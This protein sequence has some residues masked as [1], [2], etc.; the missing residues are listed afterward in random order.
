MS[1]PFAVP[2]G[3]GACPLDALEEGVLELV[4]SKLPPRDV[5]SLACASAGLRGAVSRASLRVRVD[6]EPLSRRDGSSKT[7]AEAMLAAL[8]A[9]APRCATLDLTGARVSDAAVAACVSRLPHLRAVVLD[10]CHGISASTVDALA[11]DDPETRPRAVALVSLQRCFGLLDGHGLDLLARALGRAGAKTTRAGASSATTTTHLSLSHRTFHRTAFRVDKKAPAPAAPPR[12]STSVPGASLSTL[13]LTNCAFH[14]SASAFVAALAEGAPAL[15]ALG[16]GGS[17]FDDDDDDDVG[18]PDAR[19]D[20]DAAEFISAPGTTTIPP[21]SNGA[22][23]ARRAAALARAFASSPRLRVLEATFGCPGDPFA[24]CAEWLA[25]AVD[26]VRNGGRRADDEN[27]NA[28]AADRTTEEPPRRTGTPPRPPP[29]PSLWDASD[30][31]CVKAL[32]EARA[33]NAPDGFAPGLS[34]VLRAAANCAPP[35]AFKATPLHHAVVASPGEDDDDAFDEK[36]DTEE[37]SARDARESSDDLRSR[38]ARALRDRAR[39]MGAGRVTTSAATSPPSGRAAA[40]RRLPFGYGGDARRRRVDARARP[41]PGGAFNVVRALL[42]FGADANARDRSGATPLFLAAEGGHREAAIDLLDAGA[43]L[44]AKNALGESAPYIAALKGR[45]RTLD[46]LLER[47]RAVGA[48]WQDPEW[49]GDGWTPLHAAACA[50]REDVAAV[51]IERAREEEEEEEEEEEKEGGSS[52]STARR[53]K[54]KEKPPPLLVRAKNRYG[55]TALHVAALLGSAGMVR[56]LLDAGAS[57]RAR[58]GNGMR[59]ADVAAREGHAEVWELLLEEAGGEE[60]DETTSSSPEDE[61][62][63]DAKK[64]GGAEAGG[65][66]K[67]GGRRRRRRRRGDRRA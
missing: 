42:A 40:P 33:A 48:P 17:R 47:C 5:A 61:E 66:R 13:S 62:E 65:G 6:P 30:A 12:A 8:P 27:E 24:P 15:E 26:R 54:T 53:K 19:L 37:T 35:K 52:S 46:A 23:A 41:G 49:Y 25:P 2:P 29:P 21:A 45:A 22:P 50:N 16:V 20:D 32:A 4:L 51:L 63:E 67:P 59:P 64:P 58:D 7:E 60:D 34:A 44:A 57:T 10:A 38:V 18:F 36:E 1:A 31:A 14:C 43:E 28:R 11:D 9:L 3:D 39:E 56:T 55:A